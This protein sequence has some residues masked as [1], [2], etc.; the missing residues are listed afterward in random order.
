MPL[1]TINRQ[2]MR[3]NVLASATATSFGS[4]CSSSAA[5][6]GVDLCRPA[7]TCLRR[8]VAPTINVDRSAESPAFVIPPNFCLPT[9]R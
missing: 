2:A 4:F 6:H 9:I 5:S 7:Q 8:A 3:A 1:E